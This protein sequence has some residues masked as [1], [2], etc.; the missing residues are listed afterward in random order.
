[1]RITAGDVAD[2]AAGATLLGSGGGGE[3]TNVAALLRHVLTENGPVDVVPA[4]G[5]DPESWVV[6][7]ATIGAMT[8]LV[9]RPPSG[10]EFH[11]AVRALEHRL[12]ITVAA[13]HGLE[14]A[15]TNALTPVAAAAWLGL[16]L[17]DGDGMGRAYPR[18]DQTVFTLAG[19][20]SGPVVLSEPSGVEVTVAGTNGAGA[21]RLARAALPA[22]GGWAVMAGFALRARE[23][24]DHALSGTVSRALSLG[25]AL[26]RAQDDPAER[27]R[28]LA[29][30]SGRRLF[31]GTVMQ[32]RQRGRDG[33]AYGTVTV[34]HAVTRERT[35][36]LEM[37]DEYLLALD[38]GA[39]TARVPDI[40][41]VVH[42]RTWLPISTEQ[43]APGQHVD[44]LRLPAPPELETPAAAALMG[45]AAFGLDL[46]A[47]TEPRD[48]SN[49]GPR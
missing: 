31:T 30:A 22:L 11:T 12:G 10:P 39:V 42:S 36:R 38:D 25:R 34:E 33:A 19:L 5:L 43:V 18:I 2:L 14:N 15:G 40:I 3:T 13:I 47:P 23:S 37:A 27:D 41:A 21:E 1:V 6:P 17:V 24:R 4:A 9:E 20:P 16:P 45:P 8:V 49:G 44:V 32:V 28:L 48:S 26:R 35:L 7:I 29:E 46:P